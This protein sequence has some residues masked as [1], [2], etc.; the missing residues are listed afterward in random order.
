MGL[1]KC[2]ALTKVTILGLLRECNLIQ[3]DCFIWERVMKDKSTNITGTGI[4]GT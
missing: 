3:F 4:N 1:A 2:L